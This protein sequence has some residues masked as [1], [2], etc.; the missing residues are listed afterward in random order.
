MFGRWS[1]TCILLLAA[2]ATPLAARERLPGPIPA[3]VAVV[4]DGDTLRVK[5]RVWLGQEVDT[6]VRLLGVDAPEL[7]G[8]CADER[9]RAED[10]RAFVR[11][12][13]QDRSVT[14]VDVRTDKYGGRVLARVMAADGTDL[15]AALVAA[16]LAK[17]SRGGRR[18]PWCLPP[19]R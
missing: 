5:A 9:R 18:V 12:R 6:L 14:L 8:R 3:S 4:I 11:R 1:Y 15:G 7:D 19:A 10:A 16:G 2:L 13:T 17:A